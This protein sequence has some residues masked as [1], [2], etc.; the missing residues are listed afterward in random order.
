MIT[1]S[2]GR[3]RRRSWALHLV[4]F[5]IGAT[6]V[7]WLFPARSGG[8]SHGSQVAPLPSDTSFV[9]A[10]DAPAAPGKDERTALD[11]RPQ[12]PAP[13][14]HASGHVF[15]ALGEAFQNGRIITGS[16]PHRLI[17]F[18]FDDGP[19]TRS[20]P[21]LLDRL[22]EAGVKAVFF[23]VASRIA[24]STPIERRQANV[25]REIARRGHLIG[26]H[27]LDHVQL[28]LLDDDAVEHQLNESER[29]FSQVL[30]G[31]PWLFRPPFGAHSQRIDQHLA[32]H[33][34][35]PVLWNLGAGDFQV[36]TTEEVV[37]LWL[38]VFERRARENGDRGGIILLHDTYGWSVD[39]FE[40]IFAFLQA[41]NCELLERHEE[42]YD[43]VDDP[44]F[45]YVPRGD[46]APETEALPAEPPPEVLAARQVALRDRTARRC[47][48]L[49]SKF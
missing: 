49:A 48:S 16:T 21:L 19:D 32:A 17:L 43:I 20:T 3:S 47:K 14:A 28:P 6:L 5:A 26:G 41:R 15:D 33:R 31:K 10:V 44:T 18:T 11:A 22:D 46:A 9:A 35:T 42:L 12:A 2:A 1:G 8:H 40:R 38:K 7:H 25:A 23:L 36:K 27:T 24:G 13:D 39:A 37:D 29:I 30:G 4:A 34:Y 45:F